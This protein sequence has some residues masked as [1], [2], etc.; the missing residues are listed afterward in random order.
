MASGSR[1]QIATAGLALVLLAALFLAY[2]P[3]WNGGFVWDDDSYV[4]KPELH[5]WQGLAR[6]WTDVRA[7]QQYFPLLHSVFWLEH[8]L[9]GDH[10]LGYHLVNIALHGLTALLFWRLLR[11]V[12]VP[13]AYLA[14]T[15]FALHPVHVESVAWIAELKNTLSGVFYLSAALAY[16]AFDRTRGKGWYSLALVLFVAAVLSKTTTAT[17]P[18]A[19]LVILWWKSGRL[20]WK[21]DVLPLVPFFLVGAGEGLFTAWVECHVGE[22]LGPE[23][24]LGEIER[25]LIAGRAFWF[26]LGKLFWPVDLAPIY[27][28]WPINSGVGW[29]YL[30][31]L[32]AVGLLAILWRMRGRH[33]A[34]LAVIL[35]FAGTLFPVLGFLNVCFFRCS[36]VADHFLYL[37]S[38][39]PVAFVASS[40]G[41]WGGCDRSWS[42]IGRWA[43]RG[44]CLGLVLVLGILSW[45]Q[46]AMYRDIETLYLTMIARNPACWL[47]HGNLGT[48]LLEAG[49][50]NEAIEHSEQALRIKP[51]CAEAHYNMGYAYLHLDRTKEAFDR[52]ALTV[53]MNPDMV[54]AQINLANLLS[55]SGLIAEAKLH[56]EHA[57]KVN[58]NSAPAHYNYGNLLKQEGRLLE[59]TEHYQEAVQINPRYARARNNWGVVLS[60]LGRVREAIEQFTQAVQIEPDFSEAHFNLCLLFAQ[61]GQFGK[62]TE[63]CRQTVR[64]LGDQP[65]LCRFVAWLMA[66][67]DSPQVD[68]KEAV[69]L[70]Q[71]ACDLTASKDSLC[72]DT[73][74]VA[75]ASAG[76]FPEAIA[77]AKEAWQRANATGQT[78]L[79]EDIHMR[80]QLYRDHKPY[81]ESVAKPQAVPH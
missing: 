72:L 8:R 41:W 58:P 37:P 10:T 47:A 65:Q 54:A 11:R 80:L 44:A 43:G 34:P 27:P 40:I 7:A 73:L 55:G 51:D 70:A 22:A 60:G 81:R 26:Y 74:A 31:P 77:T 48:I 76:Q 36:F 28:R 30:F 50:W 75:Y 18:G 64:L 46:S 29:Q 52:F 32:A 24:A 59:A 63:H 62:A 12:E 16:L 71:Q 67:T 57:L 4:L 49:R 23:F 68:P 61:N 21:P 56:Y 17:L 14:A 19:L 53:R 66:T 79:A 5:S 45:R 13:Y 69:R 1:E 9:W 3:A 39:A 2:Q 33:R 15:I 38:L 42:R 25:C 35:V 6:I 20:T 78:S